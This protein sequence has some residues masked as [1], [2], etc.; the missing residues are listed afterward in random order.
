MN[1]KTVV[2]SAF[3]CSGKTYAYKNLQ[4]QYSI[5]DIDSSEFRYKYEEDWQEEY[6]KVSNPEFPQNYIRSI[7]KNIGKVDIIFVSSCLQVRRELE[8]ANIRYCTVYPKENMINEWVGRM[9]R[10][11]YSKE[12][13]QYQIDYWNEF[14]RNITHEPH[15]FGICRLG[16]NEYLDV[17]F[18][19]NW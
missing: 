1:K 3:P 6:V 8:K 15:G 10:R 4:N 18:L 14:M 11:G 2:V 9:Y 17:D 7:K 13:I 19:Y 12:F 16:N 5:L